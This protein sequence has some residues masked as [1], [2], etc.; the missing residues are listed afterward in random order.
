MKIVIAGGQ[1]GGPIMPLLAVVDEIKRE[2]SHVQV[3]VVDTPTS[4]AR[5]IA[6]KENLH[7]YPFRT[8]KLRRY[9]SVRTLL[10]PFAVAWGFLSALRLLHSFKPNL[11]M[12]AGGFIQVPVVWAAW[13]LRIP[14]LLHQQDVVPT[15]SNSLSA[16]FAKRITATFEQS[17]RDFHSGFGFFG[18]SKKDKKP[19][20][21]WTGNPFR[22]S[23]LHASREEARKHFNLDAKLPVLLVTGGGSGAKR[24]NN[25]IYK[26]LPD[27]TKAVQVIHGTG[28]GKK[29]PI[30]MNHYH[31][32]EFIDRMDLAYAVADIV[33]S[34]AGISTITELANLGKISIIIPLPDTHQEFNAG[35]LYELQAAIVMDQTITGP[36]KIV[37]VIRR[38]LLD[39]ETQ[40]MMHKNISALMPKHAAAK[41]A[42][43]AL[44]LSTH[45]K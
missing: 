13:L 27:L 30:V 14:V 31:A 19:L 36:E 23:L 32:Y 22:E 5:I 28:T 33:I 15:L 43:L 29:D 42:K 1:T 21:V 17:Q 38:L 41:I 12:G 8:G 20:V 24:L 16:P 40:K 26:A 4:A 9:W 18:P 37:S 39:G 7:F 10:A 35:L 45:A 44:E 2:K 6:A 25:L 11:V 34:R 3:M